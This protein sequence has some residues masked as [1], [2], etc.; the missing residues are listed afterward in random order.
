MPMIIRTNDGFLKVDGVHCSCL[1][2]SLSLGNT[3]NF[4]L[5]NQV[6]NKKKR[7]KIFRGKKNLDVINGSAA[8]YS[9]FS[10][11]LSEVYAKFIHDFFSLKLEAVRIFM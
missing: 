1:S 2:V 6:T 5:L 3:N 10:Q 9:T 7:K 11:C 8:I 4:S